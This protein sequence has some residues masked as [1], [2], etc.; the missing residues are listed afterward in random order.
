MRRLVLLDLDGTLVGGGVGRRALDRAFLARYGWERAT[1]GVSFA[2][3]TDPGIV[4]A[5]FGRFGRADAA[6][7]QRALLADYVRELGALLA[8]CEASP[9]HAL[10]GA[11]AYLARL[12]G[13]ARYEV[14]VLTGNVEGGARLKLRAAGLGDGFFRVGAFGDD[15]TT[16]PGLLPVALARANALLTPGAPAWRAAECVVVGDTPRDIEVARAH[17]A[18]AVAVASGAC[19][20]AELDAHAPDVLLDALE[21][22]EE[23]LAALD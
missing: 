1:S 8:A 21:P 18:R 11:A 5:V 6:A 16:R 9:V 12:S 17:G 22:L 15:A 3:M 19:S 14:A 2:G 10:P 20:R 13:A 4:A 23:A 7:E